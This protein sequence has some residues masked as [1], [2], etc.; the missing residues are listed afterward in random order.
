MLPSG[1]RSLPRS[2][3]LPDLL[4]RLA[5]RLHPLCLLRWGDGVQLALV[6]G[7]PGILELD[8]PLHAVEQQI[9]DMAVSGRQVV[10]RSGEGGTTRRAR[11]VLLDGWP[12]LLA[13]W[14]Q[15]FKVGAGDD[16]LHVIPPL[17]KAT[18]LL[19]VPLA[20]EIRIRLD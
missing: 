1:K 17:H 2:G 7:E 3:V 18:M 6:E 16:V 8:Y 13:E 11:R 12:E 9:A 19:L 5:D 10:E 4:W 20:L 15:A 14:Q